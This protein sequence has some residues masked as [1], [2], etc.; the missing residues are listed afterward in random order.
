MQYLASNWEVELESS[1][2]PQLGQTL[3]YNILTKMDKKYLEF[4]KTPA[5]KEYFTKLVGIFTRDENGKAVEVNLKNGEE[6]ILY[7]DK[8]KI[9]ETLEDGLLRCLKD[10]F[11]LKIR[12]FD[13]L[14]FA[15][16]GAKNK[17]G[18]TLPRIGVNVYVE[19][20]NF[21]NE[22]VVGGR[23]K[24]V[25]RHDEALAWLGKGYEIASNRF[26][27]EE[28]TEFVNKLYELGAIDVTVTGF[29]REETNY[30]DSIDIR[31]PKEAD[32]R[33]KIFEITNQEVKREFPD[34]E[35]EADIGQ[36]EIT[37]WWD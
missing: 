33:E 17:S 12:D 29:D 24:W 6:R 7:C 3:I 2:M 16:D 32:L 8:V 31:L 21:K 4:L 13:V 36:K 28:A 25:A 11:G 37:L 19:Y 26:S 5:E 23:A 10:D 1:G 20:G 27:I 9:G 22:T 34:E 35:V 14:A 18:E 15:I 30:S